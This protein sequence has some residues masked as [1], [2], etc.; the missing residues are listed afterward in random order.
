M[1]AY[2][3]TIAGIGM[4]VLVIAFGGSAASARANDQ[5]TRYF[6][7]KVVLDR[8]GVIAPWYTGQNGQL[9]ERVRIAAE[10]LKRYPWT[11]PGKAPLIAPEYAYNNTW[12]I[13][14]D[15]TITIP[16]L[17]NWANGGRGQATARVLDAWVDYYRYSGDPAAKAQIKVVADALLKTCLTAP[18]YP[19]PDFLISV[20]VAGKPYGQA[21]DKGFIQ[22]DIVGEAGV[23]LLAAYQLT[24]DVR[25]FDIVKHWGDVFAAKRD[26]RPG[27]AP[28]DR[29]A[30]PGDVPWGASREGRAQTGGV[31]YELEM[32]DEL[33]RLGYKGKN[34]SIV[35]A[36]DAARA[37]IKDVLLPAWLTHDTW[38][39]NYWDW[40]DPVQSQTTTDWIA[41]YFMDH[42]REFPNWRNDVRNILTLFLNHTSVSPKSDGGLYSGAWAFPESDGCCGRS[43]AWGP[44]FLGIDF[45]QYGSVAHDSWG[46]EMARRMEILATY[47]FLENGVVD[48]KIDGGTVAAGGWFNGT[49]P[50]AL[51][52]ALEAI[53]WMPELT[54]PSRENH[55][56]RSSAIVN[57][58]FYG[59][60]EITY[61]TF[62]AP[63]QTTTVLRLSFRPSKVMADGRA[64]T[65]YRSATD[66]SANGYA[67]EA[68]AN[69]D[70]IVTVREDGA[71]NVTIRGADPQSFADDASLPYRGVWTTRRNA[72][73][74][75]GTEH[76]TSTSG[77]ELE[78]GFTGNQVR[79]LSSVGPQGGEAAVYVD[80]VKQ[81]AGIDYWN[82]EALYKQVVYYRN[83]LPQ[84]Q[85]TIRIVA[86][87][88]RNPYSTGNEVSIDGIETS[89]ATGSTSF[90]E[91]G[92]PTGTQRMI[93]GYPGRQD[94]I[95][96]NG[97]AWRP[98]T[99]FVVRTGELTDS[100]DTWWTLKQA[101][102]IYDTP[103]PDLYS[104]GVHAPDF[105]VGVTVAPGT[106]HV[107]L[108]FAETHP[109]SDH[110]RAMD[111]YV[112]GKLEFR[113][114]D[115]VATAKREEET[116]RGRLVSA[117][118]EPFS[119]HPG[120]LGIPNPNPGSPLNRAVDLVVNDVKP[121]NGLIEI[122][123]MGTKVDGERSEAMLQALEVGPGRGSA[124]DAAVSAP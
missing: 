11:P 99:E 123:L 107:R 25:Y 81:P 74:Y 30:N 118:Y 20:P 75:E 112:N 84:G 104:Y 32:M 90:G 47:D 111:V 46:T 53:A 37:Y 8:Y 42:Q 22:L 31:V 92:G 51:Y 3:S 120:H 29:Y 38:G 52:Y 15:G 72:S 24:G 58:V 80:G 62:D 40:Q 100:V 43:L 12:R 39:R 68:L 18:S 69:G 102:T 16:E 117:D 4:C 82:P 54:A 60:G 101:V 23:A 5:A 85:H 7:H 115:I 35:A 44:L 88:D 21:S 57:S 119:K 73:A 106:Y 13:A 50:S 109:R 83:G 91:G 96:T 27:K 70:F 110:A 79:V 98:A 95:D 105:T 28:W 26:R 67:A 103:D 76:V 14:P 63:P 113:H 114:L 78:F 116:N 122:R 48:D 10:T 45:A 86:L 61:S 9:D 97:N 59:D 64:L 65:Y 94:Y 2:R 71:K 66:L 56:V 49:H 36:R 41:R 34:G 1:Q 93:F 87:H 89:A 55:I 19:W 108:L 124:G 33:I 6:A 77:S 121:K 17:T